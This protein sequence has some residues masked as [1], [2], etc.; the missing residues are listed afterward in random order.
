M[1][2]ML[3]STV[4]AVW[5][6]LVLLTSLSWWLTDGLATNDAELMTVLAVVLIALAMF[7][8]RLVVIYF[9]EIRDAPWMLRAVMEAWI[10]LVFVGIVGQYVV[11]V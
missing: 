2:E 8:V 7:K 10:V 11:S 1:K 6:T 3:C 9:M 4:S 5:L